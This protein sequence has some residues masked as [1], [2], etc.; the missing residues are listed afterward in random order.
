MSTDTSLPDENE[1]KGVL[2][3]VQTS[4]FCGCIFTTF[5]GVPNGTRQTTE[6]SLSFTIDL[7]VEAA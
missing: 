7:L 4:G 5:C 6:Q 3:R 2:K 1:R